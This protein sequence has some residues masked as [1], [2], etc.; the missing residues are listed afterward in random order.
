MKLAKRSQIRKIAS[1]NFPPAQG[2]LRNSERDRD[3]TERGARSDF[4]PRP[5]FSLARSNV[6]LSHTGHNGHHAKKSATQF[7]RRVVTVLWS[8]TLS[9]RFLAGGWIPTPHSIRAPVAR[10]QSSNASATACRSFVT[11]NVSN[12]LPRRGQPRPHPTTEPWHLSISAVKIHS[13]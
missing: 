7:L 10:L 4:P 3:I 12:V 1:G 6:A 13:R 11:P 2:P 9:K 8:A 5:Q